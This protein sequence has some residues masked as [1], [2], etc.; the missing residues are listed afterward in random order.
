MPCED[1]DTQGD[2]RAGEEAREESPQCPRRRPDPLLQNPGRAHP[3]CLQPP[4]PLLCFVSPSSRTHSPAGWAAFPGGRE[5][6]GSGRLSICPMSHSSCPR[7]AAGLGLSLGLLWLVLCCDGRQS[8]RLPSVKGAMERTPKPPTSFLEARV[9]DCASQGALTSADVSISPVLSRFGTSPPAGVPS[10][11]FSA[12]CGPSHAPA[13]A[14]VAWFPSLCTALEL[15]RRR[16]CRASSV[17]R[18]LRPEP[19]AEA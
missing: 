3:R 12:S 2:A 11:P 14:R 1:G 9:P 19:K 15:W 17:V 10:I 13:Q 5:S 7:A 16:S 6:A 8:P 4:F 18:A